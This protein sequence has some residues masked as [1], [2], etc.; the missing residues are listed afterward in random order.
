MSAVGAD[1]PALG[2]GHAERLAAIVAATGAFSDAVP[3]IEALLA[4]VAEQI[5]RATGDF[6]SVVLLS[7]DGAHIEPVAAY[8]P[9]PQVLEDAAAFLGVPLELESAGV[10]KAVIRDR[11]SAV[12]KID[13]DHLPATVA[14]HQALHIRKWRIR[15]AAMI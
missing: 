11:R 5:S 10:W 3:D 7:A 14:P 1:A 6:C 15:E 4:I 12:L 2:G 13:P 9:D 8:H